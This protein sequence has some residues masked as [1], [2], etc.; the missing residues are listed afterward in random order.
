M[1]NKNK[2]YKIDKSGVLVP[3]TMA[4]FKDESKNSIYS[5]NADLMGKYTNE[6]LHFINSFVGKID[7]DG[8]MFRRFKDKVKDQIVDFFKEEIIGELM[9]GDPEFS[10]VI[11]FYFANA[12]KNEDSTVL[13]PADLQMPLPGNFQ[14]IFLPSSIY[15]KGILPVSHLE[16]NLAKVG[17]RYINYKKDEKAPKYHTPP[18]VVIDKAFTNAILKFLYFKSAS[19]KSITEDTYITQTLPL[20]FAD[21]MSILTDTINN[22]MV[23][24]KRITAYSNVSETAHK[25]VLSKQQTIKKSFAAKQSEINKLKRTIVTKIKESTEKDK[26]IEQLK[27]ALEAEKSKNKV[28]YEEL[29]AR[30]FELKR[31]D[32]K[33]KRNYNSLLEKYQAML[34]RHGEPEPEEKPC[35]TETRKLDLNGRYI[36]LADE[37][38]T[39]FV[40]KIKE[41]F[42]NAIVTDSPFN[43]N[44]DAIDLAIVVTSIIGHS[45][46]NDFKTQCKNKNIPIVHCPFLNI[47][48]IKQT[49]ESYVNSAFKD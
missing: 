42:P 39:S 12:V 32:D 27:A 28:A 21:F 1:S 36:F 17:L 18:E 14:M 3:A 22:L 34:Q 33:T 19:N 47:E 35:S 45:M 24:I 6:H 2:L 25:A 26:E 43:I 8:K 41:A 7:V 9:E 20:S 49:M 37:S 44:P 48:M 4:D 40:S 10:Q 38:K 13:T 11:S 29:L 23:D 46:Y 31:H 16:K 30:N 5:I 15:N